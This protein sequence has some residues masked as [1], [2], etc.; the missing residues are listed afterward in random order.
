MS[1]TRFFVT[2]LLL[3]SLVLFA[4]GG[5]FA[6][7]QNKTNKVVVV[8]SKK[9]LQSALHGK[10][11][12]KGKADEALSKKLVENAKKI[13][14]V[15]LPKV[16]TSN[17]ALA[18]A[19]GKQL[20]SQGSAC[21]RK[22]K[23]QVKSL[24]LGSH[25]FRCGKNSMLLVLNS[26]KSGGKATPASGAKPTGEF[27]LVDDIIEIVIVLIMLGGMGVAVTDSPSSDIEEGT[28]SETIYCTFGECDGGSPPEGSS[29]E[30]GK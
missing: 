7:A 12:L 8:N 13:N 4:S 27:F 14:G 30:A 6:V 29:D 10:N 20:G 26:G 3:P 5:G 16:T 15:G 23:T 28:L 2:A 21:L 17:R 22:L 11:I 9:L 25:G 19:Y 1:I 24:K 18:K